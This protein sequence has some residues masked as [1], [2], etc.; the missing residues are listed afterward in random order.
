MIK[1]KIKVCPECKTDDFGYKG[2]G[3]KPVKERD[4]YCKNNHRFEEFIEIEVSEN[5]KTSHNS[6]K[7]QSAIVDTYNCKQC[8][9]ITH[10]VCA[11]CGAI[12]AD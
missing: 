3:S 4:Y 12:K 6:R 8:D 9:S 11:K 7:N 1:H 5:L 2:W 10:P